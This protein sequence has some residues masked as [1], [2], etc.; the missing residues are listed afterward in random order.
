MNTTLV[1]LFP[2][3]WRSRFAEHLERFQRQ[4]TRACADRIDD[5]TDASCDRGNLYRVSHSLL[6]AHEDKTCHGALIASLSI[7]WG[8]AKGDEDLGGYHLVWTRDLVNS[9]TGLLASGEVNTPFRALIYLASAQLPDGG[10]HQNFWINGDPY[11]KGVQL[12]EVAFPILLAWRLR[13][14]DAL[15]LFDPYPM[16]KAA[17]AYLVRN[18]PA[19]PQERSEE[20]SGYSPSTLAVHISALVCASQF[21][22]EHGD[23]DFSSYLL[24]SADFLDQHLEQWTFTIEGSIHPEIR[25]HYIRMLP[26]NLDDPHAEENPNTAE[27]AIRNRPADLKTVFAA[28]EVIDAGFSELVR[29]GVRRA[30]DPLMIDSVKVVDRALRVETFGNP[31]WRRYSY[32]GYGQRADGGP[33]AGVG[34]GRAWPL[35]TGERAHYELAAGREPGSLVQA[36]ENFAGPTG[37]LT[38]QIWDEPDKPEARMWFGSQPVPPCR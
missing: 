6:L 21:T 29:Y 19:T 22:A 20:N 8:E 24:A 26:I 31:C 12:D 35:L 2:N 27:I 34:Q 13:Q 4:W 18:G 28:R 37:M 23:A 38:E 17:A 33:F 30:D 11:W 16:V 9:A 3:R 14:L 32:D 25:R 36:I 1:L 7:P 15:K 10:F 5:V